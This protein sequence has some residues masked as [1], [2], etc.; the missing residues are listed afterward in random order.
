VK[1]KRG[2]CHQEEEVEEDGEELRW[3]FGKGCDRLEALKDEIRNAERAPREFEETQE[4]EKA[5]ICE[6]QTRRGDI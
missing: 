4:R 6:P 2:V 3:M 1:L 5:F